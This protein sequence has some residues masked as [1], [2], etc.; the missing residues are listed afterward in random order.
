MQFGYKM[1]K[2]VKKFQTLAELEAMH[3]QFVM[4][5]VEGNKTQASLALGIPISVLYRKCREYGIDFDGVK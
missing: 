4:N 5:E 3:I 1:I 2:L